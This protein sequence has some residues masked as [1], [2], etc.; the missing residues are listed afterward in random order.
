MR[1]SWYF[2]TI[3]SGDPATWSQWRKRHFYLGQAGI[4]Q[5]DI[6]IFL[7]GV[8]A[9]HALAWSCTV[10]LLAAFL[11]PSMHVLVTVA[12]LCRNDVTALATFASCNRVFVRLGG[13]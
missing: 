7:Q 6:D 2:V 5:T 4:F 8:M 13:W 12:D 10:Y 9:R 11:G 3:D 1:S